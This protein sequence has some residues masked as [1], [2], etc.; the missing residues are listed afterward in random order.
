MRYEL[1]V[2]GFRLLNIRLPLITVFFLIPSLAWTLSYTTLQDGLEY[3]VYSPSQSQV[4]LHFLRVDLKKL[5]V[6]PMD[7][8]EFKGIAMPIKTMVQKSGALAGINANFFDEQ[9][10]PL[11][12]LMQEGEI[13]NKPRPVQWWAALL[14]KGDRATISKVSKPEEVRGYDSGIQAGPR[15]VVAGNPPTLKKEFSPKSAVGIDKKGRLIFT[16]SEGGIAIDE[17]AK[18]LATPEAQGGGGLHYALNLDGGSSTQFYV[19]TGDFE[20]SLP[21]LV[22]VPVGLGIFEKQPAHNPSRPEG[23]MNRTAIPRQ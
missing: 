23:D 6:R 2:M 11:G 3:A 4:K 18:V 9:N 12:L 21:G 19:N 15:L 1:W 7:A 16:A 22:G 20:R 14:I 17:L 13:K 10:R 5:Q 8:R